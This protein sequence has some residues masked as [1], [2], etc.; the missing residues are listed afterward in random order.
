MK[1]FWDGR[2]IAIPRR[3]Y[4]DC[5]TP[6]YFADYKK[7]GVMKNYLFDWVQ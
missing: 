3:L 1:L 2:Q 6:P 4:S 5:Y 7:K